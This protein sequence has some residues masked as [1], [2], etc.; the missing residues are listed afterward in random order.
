MATIAEASRPASH[1]QLADAPETI[2]ELTTTQMYA[3]PIADQQAIQLAGAR[4]RFEEQVSA[5]RVVSTLAQEQGVTAISALSDLGPLLL[6]HSAYKSYPMRLL[7]QSRFD[8]ITAWLDGFTTHDLSGLD[9][10]DCGSIDE[11]LALMDAQTE[12]RVLHST[13]TSGKLSFLPRG[14]LEMERMVTGWRRL[15]DPFR[16]EPPRLGVPVEQAPTIFCQYRSGAMA[17]HRLLDWLEARLYDGDSSKI[18]TTNPGKF[19][20]DAASVSGRMRVAESRGEL[21]TLQ[22]APALLARRDAFIAD[23]QQASAHFDRFFERLAMHRGQ[24]V[25][26]MAHVPMLLNVAQQG[27]KRGYENMFATSSFIQAGGGLKGQTLPEDWRETVD[28]FFGGAPLSDGYGMTEMVA[29]T[30]ACPEGRYHIPP[31]EIPFLLDPTTG[32]Q[33]PRAGTQTGRFA[34]FDLNAETY[35][36]GFVTGDEVTLSWGDDHPC[37]CGRI[38]PYVHR[39]I[40][41]YSEKEGGDDKVTCAGAPEAHDKALDYMISMAGA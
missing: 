28:R 31:W 9:A 36:G 20:A 33:L 3:L 35:W 11:W 5:I 25:T 38:G 40:R 15:F 26:I 37:E 22:L 24:P 19:S 2:I 16:Q 18:I 21:G 32:A 4:K 34:C 10:S 13:G 39:G 6:P 7:E 23:Q 14:T 17:Q 27:L 30:R 12:V 29:S 41:R 8:R 1:T